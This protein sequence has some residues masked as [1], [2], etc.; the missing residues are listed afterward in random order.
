MIRAALMLWTVAGT[1]WADVGYLAT[2][3]EVDH[4]DVPVPLHL[5]YPATADAPRAV[6]GEDPLFEGHTARPGA[7]PLGEP[8]PLVLLS[9][10]SG[11]NGPGLGWLAASLAERGMIVAAPD[12]PGTTSGDSLPARTVMPWERAW[13][14]VAIH[15]RMRR[16]PPGGLVPDRDRVAAMGFSLGG[17]TALR[18]VGAQLS[19]DAF[20]DYCEGRDEW[21]CG[22]L[23][24]GGVDFEAIEPLLYEGR[25]RDPRIDVAVAVD[26]GLT[27]A[28][29]AESLAE[30]E[31]EVLVVSLGS[32][33]A[34]DAAME[35]GD[36]VD[37]LPDARH[38]FVEGSWHFSFLPLCKPLPP[39]LLAE[40]TEGEAICEDAGRPRAEIHAELRDVIGDYLEEALAE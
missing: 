20:I 21:D 1:A 3:I 4:R 35:A 11:G 27:Q 19:K 25:D 36:V 17:H 24:R 23:R 39:E 16:D 22:W 18:V 33:S 8:A 15:E 2:E 13:D 37:A 30:V 10:G 38:V 9:H 26:P 40:M 31:A 6:L 29:T 12:H 32:E 28:T 14:V 5:W 7:T 34:I